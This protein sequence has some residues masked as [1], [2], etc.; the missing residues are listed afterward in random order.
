MSTNPGA[1]LTCTPLQMQAGLSFLFYDLSIKR[2]FQLHLQA[3]NT[4]QIITVIISGEVVPVRVPE[5][6]PGVQVGCSGVRAVPEIATS[7]P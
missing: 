5:R 2:A 4:M 3:R 6:V 7:A 1:Y